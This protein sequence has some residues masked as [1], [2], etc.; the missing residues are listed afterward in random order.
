V[1]RLIDKLR[2]N[3]IDGRVEVGVSLWVRFDPECSAVRFEYQKEQAARMIQNEV[4]GEF[5]FDIVS[6]IVALGVGKYDDAN[7]RLRNVFSSMFDAPK[8]KSESDND[9]QA[10]SS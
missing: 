10:Q 1:S 5:Y 7:Q 9:G 2:V 6:A 8:F 4:F 3:E